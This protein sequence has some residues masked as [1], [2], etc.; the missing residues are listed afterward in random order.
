VLGKF[1]PLHKGHQH[2]IDTARLHSQLVT[3]LVCSLSSE[4]IPGELRYKWMK[5]SYPG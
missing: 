5:Q 2:L 4:P 1:M 3:I